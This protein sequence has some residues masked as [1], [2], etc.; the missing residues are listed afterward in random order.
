LLFRLG[1][2]LGR[3][4]GGELQAAVRLV[5]GSRDVEGVED[6][7]ELGWVGTGKF[8]AHVWDRV[9]HRD[10]LLGAGAGWAFR[11]MIGD[12]F[13]DRCSLRAELFDAAR[14]E[15]DD[16]VI[17]V[18]MLLEPQGLAVEA[19]LDLA[20]LALEPFELGVVLLP[21]RVRGARELQPEQLQPIRAEDPPREEVEQRLEH[22]VLLDA[23][24]ARVSGRV[25]TGRAATRDVLA[26][27]PVEPFWW[28]AS[29]R[30]PHAAT[31]RSA[32][33]AAARITLVVAIADH[34]WLGVPQGR[35]WLVRQA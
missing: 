21:G 25:G 10:D 29:G 6:L 34:R 17:G 31:M 4:G 22:G 7:R 16:R 26:A 2:E 15:R 18:F 35:A 9:E 14:R 8:G 13:V 12:R 5:V 11:L 33:S 1:D 32:D 23:Q 27:V 20:A 28:R 3:G 19:S 24:H 30:A